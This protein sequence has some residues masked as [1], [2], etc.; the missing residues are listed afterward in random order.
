MLLLKN[1]LFLNIQKIGK[2]MNFWIPVRV[3]SWR[4]SGSM[5]LY[6]LTK[7][8]FGPKIFPIR[9]GKKLTENSGV[10]KSVQK[11]DGRWQVSEGS[12]RSKNGR[13]NIRELNF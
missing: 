4:N 6:D 9:N 10:P 5:F 13:W 1:I 2:I 12:L 7:M 11:L 8:L 3:K